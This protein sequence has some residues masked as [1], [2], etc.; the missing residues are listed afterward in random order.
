MHGVIHAKGPR[1]T[2]SAATLHRRVLA[3]LI[4]AMTAT[5]VDV[6]FLATGASAALGAP[7]RVA[8]SADEPPC[9]DVDPVTKQCRKRIDL[10]GVP[11]T[12]EPLATANSNGN[13]TS[14]TGCLWEPVAANVVIP[15][16]LP[17]PGFSP[18]AVYS[19]CV[20]YL[21]GVRG[22]CPCAA[23][24][25][26]PAVGPKAATP[27]QVAQSIDVAT[28]LHAP[29]VSTS[30]PLGNMSIVGTPV[31]A[32]VTNWQ[33]TVSKQGCIGSV[34]VVVEAKPSL[35]FDPGDGTG[36][37]PCRPGGTRFDPAGRSPSD[38]AAAPG[39]CA[40]VY[41]RRSGFDGRPAGWPASL[42]IT[43]QVT[44]QGAGQAGAFP[45]VTQTTP[46]SIQVGEIQG[47][48]T[49]AG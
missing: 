4:V 36:L 8:A 27:Q 41:R 16:M 12:H 19:M 44:W 49:K 24:W 11:G 18:H 13:E 3:L 42:T 5:T 45:L 20:P 26:E 9:R 21:N 31:F 23:Q 32:E 6:A 30:P 14:F 43:W 7:V 37:I 34:C 48:V 10:P 25:I 28:L 1:P 15:M 29:V 22:L 39:A 38:Q 17:P 46:F 47:V 40:H 2:L 33:G 35:T